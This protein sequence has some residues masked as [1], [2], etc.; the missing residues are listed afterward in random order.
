MK[1]L[2]S[3]LIL[4]TGLT[5]LALAQAIDFDTYFED[6][7]LRID[8][9]HTANATY[10]EIALDQFSVTKTW[11]GNPKRLLPA[12]ENG[13]YVIKVHDIASNQLIYS[14]HYLDIVFEYKGEDPAKAGRKQTYHQT[15][16]I[17]CPKQKVLFT[18]DR[19]DTHHQLQHV[20]SQVIDPNDRTI[21]RETASPMDRVFAMVKNG[22]P[23]DCVDLVFV[24]EGYQKEEF[25]RFKKDA[26]RF[27][28]YLFSLKPFGAMK[29]RFNIHGVFRASAE[30]GVD[31]PADR[32]YKNT[33]VDASYD[34]FGSG[35]YVT[36]F[37]NKTLRDIASKVPHD[38]AIV[39]A[40]TEKYGGSGFYNSYTLFTSDNKRSEEIFTHEF[41]HGFAGLADEYIAESYF[42][43][44]YTRG[45]EP[46][47]P[48]I[49]AHLSPNYLKW[50]HLLT[51]GAPLPTPTEE[52][53]HKTVGLFEGAGYTKAGMYRSGL[54]CVMG[55][56]GLPFCTA[57]QDAIQDVVEFYSH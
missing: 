39:L 7:T 37:D 2:E 43:V 53:Y 41:G 46:L 17:P 5:P 33:V 40:N 49:T 34:T 38:H 14:R 47:E 4:A 6:A 13:R 25:D 30:S 57:C 18:I 8:Y 56:G 31:Y 3:I 24:A 42:D 44:Y 48:N 55:A 21:K 51:P 36:V 50:G 27:V 19:R 52:K 12:T 11:A 45:I 32:V 23:H 10:D 1:F 15:A 22:H 35:A 20:F 16:L 26:Q 28:D 29:Q 54:H 9:F